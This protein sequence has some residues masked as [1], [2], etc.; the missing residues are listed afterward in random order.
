MRTGPAAGS[1]PC[2]HR[3]YRQ[4]LSFTAISPFP[5]RHCLSDA[6]VVTLHSGPKATGRLH[7]KTALE[8]EKRTRTNEGETLHINLSIRPLHQRP[9]RVS[10]KKIKGP[11]QMLKK[12]CFG[13][14]NVDKTLVIFIKRQSV[15][16][17]S[18]FF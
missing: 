10:F 13:H 11:L 8:A 9:S 15:F 2:P 7:I 1:N 17:V 18:M 5:L 4:P 12:K 3:I 6:Q 16:P 14:K